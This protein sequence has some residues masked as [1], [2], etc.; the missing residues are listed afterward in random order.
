MLQ[1]L[2][3]PM[4]REFAILGQVAGKQEQILSTLGPSN[5][6]VSLTTIRKHC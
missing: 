1:S 5:P 2:N 3:H 4:K 6:M